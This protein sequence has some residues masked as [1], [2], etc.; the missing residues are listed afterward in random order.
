MTTDLSE[1]NACTE[2][3]NDENGATTPRNTGIFSQAAF[4]EKKGKLPQ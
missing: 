2:A 4:L 3:R 1:Y